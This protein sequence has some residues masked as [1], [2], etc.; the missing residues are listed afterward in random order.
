MEYHFRYSLTAD[1]FAEY[2]AYTSWHAPWQKKARIKFIVN[3]AFISLIVIPAGIIVSKYI[4]NEKPHHY[5]RLGIM[6]LVGLMVVL[7][8]AYYQEPFRI[9]NKVRKFVGK[10]ENSS[11]LGERELEI[12]DKEIVYV[13]DAGRSYCK[14]DSI[15]RNAV[16]KEY[17]YLY[18]SSIQGYI[19]PKR[20]FSSQKEIDE[21]DK[22][23]TEK[24]PLSSSFRS[25]GI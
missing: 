9:K 12:N 16:T 20:L 25:I 10:D 21:F 3:I 8:F 1:D 13:N 18:T 4:S 17:F 7:L 23:L 22:Y 19:I 5:L 11:I 6:I 15:T 14:W 24:I 2:N